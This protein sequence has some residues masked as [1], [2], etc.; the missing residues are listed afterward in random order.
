MGMQSSKFQ[1]VQIAHM[2]TDPQVPFDG[3]FA[4]TYCKYIQGYRGKVWAN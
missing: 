2:M 3:V 1:C 4:V